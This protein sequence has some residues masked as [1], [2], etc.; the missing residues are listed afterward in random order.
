VAADIGESVLPALQL[1]QPPPSE[2]VLT[3][4]LNEIAAVPHNLVLVLDDYHLI[5]SRVID[6]ALAFVLDHLPPRLHLVITTREDPQLP[7]AR[8]RARAQLVEVR[9]ADL[10]FTPAEAAE[11]LGAMNLSLSPDDVAALEERTEGWIAGLQLAALSLQGQRDVAAFIRAFAGDH[12]YILDYLVEEVLARQPAALRSFLLHTAILERLTG[13]L[14]DAV[15]GQPGGGARLE[16]LERGNFFVVPLDERRHWYRYHH[17]FAQVLQTHLLA[18][19]P[20]LVPTLHRRASAWYE[21]HGAAADAIRHALVARD[22]EHAASLIERA[23]PQMRR[24]R[25]EGTLLGWF[26]ALPDTLFRTRP[27]LSAH[28]AEALLATHDLD[29]VE[30]RLQ[31]AEQWLDLISTT[32]DV[33]VQSGAGEPAIVVVDEEAFRRLPGSIAVW[34]AALALLQGN[35]PASVNYAGRALD[36]VAEDDHLGRGGA[37]ALLGLAFW[38]SGDL[39]AAYRTYADGMARVEKAG[40]IPD[41]INGTIALAEIRIAQGRLRAAMHVYEHALQLAREQG[42]PALRGTADVNVGMSEIEC[43]QDNLVAATQHLLR[44]KEQGEHTG[45]PPYPYRWRVAM[46]RLRQAQGDP[47]GALDLL[48]EAARLYV[49]DFYPNVRPVA[50]LKARIWIG[51]GRLGKALGWAGEHGLSAQD[52]LSY[53]REFEHI[54]L[55]GLLLARHKSDRTAGYLQQALD[56][57]QRLLHAAEEGGRMGSAIEILVRQALAQQMRGD[58]P[59]A[60]VPLRSAL[61]LA[62][63]EGYVR[64]FVDEGPAMTVLLQEA[65]NQGM[66]PGYAGQLLTAFGQAPDQDSQDSKPRKQVARGPVEALSERELQVLRLLGS[67][68]SGPEIARELMVSPNTMNTHTKNIYSK[69]GVSNRRAAVRRAAELHLL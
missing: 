49:S 47:D 29:D 68:L 66:A 60:L 57:L 6:E 67:E 2:A 19:Q 39:D 55:A 3:T 65:A 43:E 20:D 5:D 14:C 51:Q 31:D 18:E 16:A 33:P 26:K 54:T 25:Q 58:V 44:S 24:S 13:S 12:R 9:A 22:F 63:P 56:L 10:R 37:A 38:A 59:A 30:A 45:F 17:L 50:A 11:F 15:T 8:L 64:I 4:L 41:A 52:E 69:L 61:T 40:F 1:P 28:F 36:L 48:E 23:I 53:L 42:D 32:L 34:R 7:L 46:A 27:V 62:E 21:R 35:V